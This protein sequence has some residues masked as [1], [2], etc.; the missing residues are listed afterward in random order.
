MNHMTFA[1]R[2]GFLGLLLTCSFGCS[3]S[4]DVDAPSVVLDKNVVADAF[5]DHNGTATAD[6]VKL[7]DDYF[8]ANAEAWC[9][10]GIPSAAATEVSA[11]DVKRVFAQMATHPYHNENEFRAAY[12]G[13]SIKTPSV[14][15]VVLRNGM[16]IIVTK[17][18]R[19]PG[20][21]IS[22]AQWESLAVK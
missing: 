9:L 13:T 10:T 18:F 22:T 7:V 17:F 1:L 14:G 3:S 2:A 21:A 4:T 6:E 20:P 15:V 5:G 19:S 11:D 8:A 16:Q 12:Q